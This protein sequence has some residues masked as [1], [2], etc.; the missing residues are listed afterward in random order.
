M[1]ADELG[2]ALGHPVAAEH[3]GE[4]GCFYVSGG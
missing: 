2:I 1:T 3:L 4:A